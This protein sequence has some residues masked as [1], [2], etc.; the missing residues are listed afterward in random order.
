ML[1][2]TLQGPPF[3]A[4]RIG[5]KHVEV[6]NPSEWIHSRLEDR[7]TGEAR[8]Y[9]FIRYYNSPIFDPKAPFCFVRYA[10]WFWLDAPISLGPYPNGFSRSFQGPVFVICHGEVVCIG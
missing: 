5:A 6:R 10:G 9:D 7:D 3:Q 2:L 4:T 1:R 8:E